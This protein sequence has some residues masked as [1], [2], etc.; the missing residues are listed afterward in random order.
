ML[1]NE[2]VSICIPTYNG[3]KFLEQAL[4]SVKAQTYRNIEVIIS[5]DNSTDNTLAIAENFRKDVDF[6]VHIFHHEPAGIGAN[7]DHCIEKSSGSWIKFLF[8]DDILESD[9]L[10]EFLKLQEITG[11][12]VFFSKRTIIDENGADISQNSWISD[13]QQTV[14]LDIDN[15]IVFTKNKLNI[16]GRDSKMH[17]SHNFFGEPVASFISKSAF[18]KTG[19]HNKAL[20]Q[21]LDLEY[22]L[23]L[24]K[25][26]NIVIT[27][28]KLIR[29]R[30][31]TEQAT[32]QNWN[33]NINEHNLLDW[34]IIRN[35]Y[36]YLN[37]RAILGYFY[38]RYP[39]VR[40]VRGKIRI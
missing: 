19:L 17:L 22:N 9:C 18:T 25:H 20:Q 38:R 32:Q 37:R 13:L 29:F 10:E 27:E 14:L 26:Y 12:L 5:D 33:N 11:E 7:W 36:R 2:L 39:F 34:F 3:A 8:Q 40:Y 23:R 35:F 16:L 24:L 6:P 15:Y 21:L 28:Q 4:D 30:V 1:R 31:H